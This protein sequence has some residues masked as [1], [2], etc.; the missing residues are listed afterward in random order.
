MIDAP[1]SF[2]PVLESKSFY[3]IQSQMALDF[4]KWD[5]QVGDIT[6][7]F[8]Q[9]L[10]IGSETWE[11]LK[12]TAE[13][14]ASELK[15]AEGEL[16]YRPE[17]H[18]LLGLPKRVRSL[19]AEGVESDITQC[20]VRTLRFDFH[21]TSEGWRISEVNSDVPGGYTEASRFTELI[22]NTFPG[23]RPAGNPVTTWSGAVLSFIGEGGVVAFLSAPGFLEDHQV[24]SF[25][26]SRLLEAGVK[27]VFVEDPSQLTWNSGFASTILNRKST[28]LDLVVRFYQG[29]WLA[30][31]PAS[32][33]WERIFK[34]KT[35][36]TNP[37]SSLLT[38]SKRLP[39]SFPH[40]AARTPTWQKVLP[41]CRD[42]RE[43]CWTDGSW[44][45]KAAFS[46]TGD[47][48]HVIDTR[49]GKSWVGLSR[50]V[51]RNPE[52]WVAQR[53]FHPVAV[54]SEIGPVYPCIGVFTINGRATGVYARVSIK[55]ITDY[56]AM[57]VALL[58]NGN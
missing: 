32:R 55:P 17:L 13:S 58:I 34:S 47:E 51:R 41:E 30:A 25:L 6:T 53:R 7:L 24:V 42:P 11:E 45:L 36:V 37:V 28:R 26:A 48:V 3:G 33:A 31:L 4:C 29:E 40:L 52:H 49:Y 18:G 43:V 56:S 16:L 21:F 5:S 38:E 39:L 12:V 15:A 14:L 27:T 35:P 46:N 22:C 54:L 23:T 20:P 57:D 8:R 2:G 9:A 1:L 44:V 19:F 50:L 10:V